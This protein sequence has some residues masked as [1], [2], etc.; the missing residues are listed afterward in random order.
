MSMKIWKSRRLN[1]EVGSFGRLVAIS[2]LDT[3]RVL[4]VSVGR[5]FSLLLKLVAH[6]SKH[7]LVPRQYLTW[8][9]DRFAYEDWFQLD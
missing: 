5:S 7:H 3:F 4:I 8:M 6:S 9:G 1:R 2:C